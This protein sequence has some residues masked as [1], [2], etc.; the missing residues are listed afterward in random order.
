MGALIESC[1]TVA[2][3]RK[4]ALDLADA[5]A[6]ACLRRA[7]RSASDVDLL[8]NAGV[9]RDSNLGEPALAA[10]IQ[11]DIGA[12]LQQTSRTAHG[13]FSFDVA[14]GGAGVITAIRIADGFL[15]DSVDLALVVASDAH[16]G[17][18]VSPAFPFSRVGGALL[19]VPGDSGYGF[20]DFRFD[21][22]PEFE[23][24]YSAYV[25]WVERRPGHGETV[26]VID[27]KPGYAARAVDCAVESIRRFLGRSLGDIDLLVTS[28]LPG[29]FPDA[30]ARRL[31]LPGDRV[32]HVGED[33]AGA[34]TAGVL[35]AFESAE[36]GGRVAESRQILFVG[37]GAGIG[38]GL[39][40]YVRP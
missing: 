22:Y 18:S 23:S 2:K 36:L 4:G 34:H 35:A 6:E 19:L 8:I 21:T 14:G 12:N 25:E 30:L 5:A 17:S 11:D 39:A 33:R 13:T 31:E 7:G 3:R 9:Y 27:E 38:V 15:A 1:A 29:P 32:A 24:L 40:H 10:L 37:V 28:E 26:L 20:V 16:P